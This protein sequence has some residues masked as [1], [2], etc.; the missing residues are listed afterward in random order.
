MSGKLFVISG[1]SG[2]GKTTLVTRVLSNVENLRF[3]ISYTTRPMRAGEVRGEHYEFVPREEFQGMIE[4]DFFAE[5]AEVHGNFYGTP[6]ADIQKWIETGVDV[7]LDIDVQGAKRLRGVFDDAVFIFVVPPSVEI[8]EQRLRDRKSEEDGDISIR[9]GIVKEEVACSK[10][11]DYIII[12]DEVD[13]AAGRIEAVI[14][15]QRKGNGEDSRQRMLAATR[16][17]RTE[18][19]YGPSF[20]RRFGLK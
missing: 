17:A 13:I 2:S 7:I 12:N 14:L 10:C 18:N 19:V 20:L 1:P 8:L 5:W 11:Y 6:R 15:S 3:S 9:L 4:R 16:D